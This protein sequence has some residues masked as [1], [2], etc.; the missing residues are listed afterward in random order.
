MSRR[1]LRA[2]LAAVLLVSTVL[3]A[4]AKPPDLP[5]GMQ[6]PVGPMS[7]Q[8]S[9]APT[10]DAPAPN[11]PVDLPALPPAVVEAMPHV[12]APAWPL[13]LRPREQRQLKACLLVVA[14]PLLVLTPLM[15]EKCDRGG[16]RAMTVINGV[17]CP[18]PVKMNAVEAKCGDVVRWV[19]RQ[20]IASK[21]IFKVEIN[22]VPNVTPSPAKAVQDSVQDGT[23]D[24]ARDVLERVKTN[25]DSHYQEMRDK[26]L[27]AMSLATE[28]F[29]AHE[30]NAAIEILQAF[31]DEVATDNQLD[32]GTEKVLLVRAINSR[33]KSFELASREIDSQSNPKTRQSE[34]ELKAA[35]L[36][37]EKVAALM[38]KFNILYKDC[39]Y[40]EAERYALLAQ[41]VDPDNPV[42]AFAID[43]ARKGYQREGHESPK[44]TEF[45]QIVGESRTPEQLTVIPRERGSNLPAWFIESPDILRIDAIRVVPLPAYKIEQIRGEHLCRPDGTI[46]LGPYGSVYVAGLTLHQACEAIK[47]HLS[48]NQVKTPISVDV[49]DYDSKVYYVICGGADTGQSVTRLPITG[50]ETV[51]DAISKVNG[52]ASVASNSHLWIARPGPRH[53]SEQDQILP[54]DW[55]AITRQGRTETN[56]KVLPGDRIFIQPQA[57]NRVEAPTGLGLLLPRSNHASGSRSLAMARLV[58]P[59]PRNS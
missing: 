53:T 31:K 14:N 47:E 16:D 22:N 12:P 52:L 23:N 59:P 32:P 54:I 6:T 33:I 13:G 18:A 11:A 24:E 17:V 46:A 50:N 21:E 27:K 4:S 36:K 58:N 20:V 49:I 40:E 3:R 30:I 38:K 2:C 1:L 15:D 34:E 10:G 28:K 39:K 56:Y 45:S 44:L 37:Q 29:R 51:L 7:D 48:Q 43:F 57:L 26:G 42:V 25:H 9:E 41:E 19:Q 35:R 5:L 8:D 55:Q